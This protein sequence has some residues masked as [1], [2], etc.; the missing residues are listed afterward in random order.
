MVLYN[1]QKSSRH[2]RARTHDE[3]DHSTVFGTL[4]WYHYQWPEKG[5]QAARINAAFDFVAPHPKAC[6][7]PTVVHVLLERTF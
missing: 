2:A 7:A 3:N 6:E 5:D 1:F 4:R